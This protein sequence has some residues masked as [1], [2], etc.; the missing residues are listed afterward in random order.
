MSEW[1]RR[2]FGVKD[3]MTFANSGEV[4]KEYGARVRFHDAVKDVGGTAGL[5]IQMWILFDTL[6]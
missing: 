5:Y 2:I 6:E 4:V 3:R 1:L